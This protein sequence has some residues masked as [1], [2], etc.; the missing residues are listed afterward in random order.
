MTN[1]TRVGRRGNGTATHTIIVPEVGQPFA[2]CF[3]SANM[4]HGRN[5]QRITLLP[6]GT[7]VTCKVCNPKAA[8]EMPTE[9]P[10]HCEQH[11]RSLVWKDAEIK[12]GHKRTWTCG[13]SHLIKKAK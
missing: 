5:H 9:H 1:T 2:V 6:E 3:A 8:D 13:C 12:A 10:E 4:V 11:P 7:P